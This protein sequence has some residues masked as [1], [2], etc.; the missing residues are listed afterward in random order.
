MCRLISEPAK[1][2]NR[3]DDAFSKQVLPQPIHHHTRG[4]RVLRRRRLFGQL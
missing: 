1:V 4:Q 3:P 2:V